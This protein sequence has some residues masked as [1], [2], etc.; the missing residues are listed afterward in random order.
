M[1]SI[2]DDCD[3]VSSKLPNEILPLFANILAGC[4]VTAAPSDVLGSL[5]NE[6][7]PLLRA[8]RVFFCNL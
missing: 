1:T 5:V 7:S 8:T 4:P 3:V 2:I 6:L